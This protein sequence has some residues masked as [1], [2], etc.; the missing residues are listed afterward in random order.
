MFRL[1]FT[2]IGLFLTKQCTMR[3][4]FFALLVSILCNGFAQADQKP[5]VLF[6]SIDDLNDW[7][8]CYGGHPQVKTPHIDALARRNDDQRSLPSTDLQSVAGQHVFR[9]IALDHWNVFFGT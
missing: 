2:A 3:S 6:I 9:K 4:L 5:N 7:L 8:G 1:T